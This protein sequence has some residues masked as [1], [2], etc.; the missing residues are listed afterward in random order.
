MQRE[1]KLLIEDFKDGLQHGMKVSNL[2]YLVAKEM[3]LEEG[4]CYDIAIAG[5]LH[6]IGKLELTNYLYGRNKE[7]LDVEEM[8]YMRM[9]SKLSYDIIEHYDFS[10]LTLET[11]LYHHENF[12]GSG[13]P[14]NL[15][16]ED[17]PIG[18]RVLRVTDQFIALISD[19]PYRAAFDKETAVEIMIEEVKNYD[20]EVFITFQKVINTYDIDKLM[21]D[22]MIDFGSGDIM[23]IFENGGS[24]DAK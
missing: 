23:E 20:M 17:I 15:K 9:H 5:L 18:A 24:Q 14:G 7:A 16:G 8:K 2:S 12:D 6:D 4:M 10:Y 3:K 1:D 13:Y 11:V 21:K 19:R 22:S